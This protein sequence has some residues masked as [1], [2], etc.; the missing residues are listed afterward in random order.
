MRAACIQM[1]SQND[2][3]ANITM[4]TKLITAAAIDG[5]EF[6]TTPECF[7]LMGNSD[8]NYDKIVTSSIETMQ[9]LAAK[10]QIWLLIGSVHI[11]TKQQEINNKRLNR[12][13]LIS[14]SGDIIAHYDKINLFDADVPTANGFIK[15]RES[16]EIIAGREIVTANTP[17]GLIGL[18]ICYDLRFGWLYNKMARLGVNIITIPA[19][20]TKATGELHW[21]I[22]LRARAIET[23]SFVIAPAQTGIHNHNRETFG[24]SLIIDP[25]G[26]ILADAG[27]AT[28]YIIADLNLDEVAIMRRS[29]PAT[30]ADWSY[31]DS[32]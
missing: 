23:G 4:A 21:H 13:I 26:N 27:I 1:N 22:L 32:I 15:Y 18:S 8:I 9:Q 5:A 30:T 31:Y 19:A 6:I 14:A 17:W 3:A 2:V 20:F 28:G 24:H 12:S 10:L 7:N 11:K 16:N 25:W 29:I